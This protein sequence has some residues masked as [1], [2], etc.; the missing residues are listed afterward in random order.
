M[1]YATHRIGERHVEHYA[2]I[3]RS[4]AEL[5]VAISSVH[6]W[7]EEYLTGDPQVDVQTDVLEGLD[8]ADALA[9]A[10][11]E[12]GGTGPGRGITTPL[13]ETELR[14]Q[15]RSIRGGLDQFR[16]LVRSRLRSTSGIGTALDRQFDQSFRELLD[17]TGE[18]E[19]GIEGRMLEGRRRSNVLFGAI[20]VAWLALLGLTLGTLHRREQRQA[21]TE[22]ALQHSED[23]LR[24]AQ[25]LEAVGRLAG[26]LAHDINNYLATIN[27]QAGLAKILHAET[28]GVASLMDEIIGTVGRTTS[29]IQRLLSFSRAQPSHV[30][31]VRLDVLVEE[32]GSMVRRLVGDDVQ[33]VI[34]SADGLWPVE[35]D[36]SQLE[37]VLVNLLV[38][39]SE[40]M[41]GGGRVS[42]RLTNESLDGTSERRGALAA[43]D[44]VC[45]S[46]TDEGTGIPREIRDTI[47]EPFFSTKERVA[48]EAGAHSGLGLATV[49]GIVRQAGGTIELQSAPGQGTT[50]RVFLPRTTREPE[51]PSVAET[52]ATVPAD[53]GSSRRILVVE[54]NE[55]LRRVTTAVLS[56]VGHEVLA[57]GDGEQALRRLRRGTDSFDV[58]ITDLV[59]PGASGRAVTEEVLKTDGSGVVMT[60]G[61]RDRI[62]IGDLLASERVRYLDKPFTPQDL[63]GAMAELDAVAADRAAS[64]APARDLSEEASSGR[65]SARKRRSTQAPAPP[66]EPPSGSDRDGT[67]SAP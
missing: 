48:E 10:L 67:P 37:Q 44:Y 60:S 27:T 46:V 54:D 47:F 49:F 36:P 63:L 16:T 5:R 30:Q 64:G 6:L 18:L 29:L 51:A 3:E 38:N 2:P 8:R 20:L 15:A 59:M 22:A 55:E 7:L 31:V 61:F 40:A 57:V 62:Q 13:R 12:G 24:Q 56:A 28:P 33:L 32:L 65:R 25:K 19:R 34:H 58:V 11:L 45:L 23:Q 35:A 53:T 14:E 1:L 41:P 39:A 52:P 17:A 26:G 4:A 43:G 66:G 21:Q 50:F 9:R 42:V